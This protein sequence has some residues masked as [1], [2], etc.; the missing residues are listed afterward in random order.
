M[1]IICDN[2]SSSSHIITDANHGRLNNLLTQSVF[3]R[4]P[5]RLCG[6]RPI[7]EFEPDF[8]MASSSREMRTALNVQIASKL[9]FLAIKYGTFK[10][11]GKKMYSLR[12]SHS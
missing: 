2:Y 12:K 1:I 3:A 6:G 8:A 11:Y 9:L 10:N 4:S 5:I 7:F